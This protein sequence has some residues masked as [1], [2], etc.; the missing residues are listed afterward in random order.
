MRD[1]EVRELRK[2][3]KKE[4]YDELPFYIV[5][6]GIRLGVVVGPREYNRLR[7]IEYIEK[8]RQKYDKKMGV[9]VNRVLKYDQDVPPA[10]WGL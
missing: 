8:A 9:F 5:S 10:D 4:I 7:L 2:H 6:G 3:V 1:V